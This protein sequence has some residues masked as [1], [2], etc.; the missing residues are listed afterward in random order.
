MKRFAIAVAI[1]VVL[2]GAA[3]I[4][5]LSD[6]NSA[7]ADVRDPSR[8]PGI[9]NQ[10]RT[11]MTDGTKG[12]SF[13]PASIPNSATD[14]RFF[15]RPHFLQGGA[16]LQIS[17]CLPD[18][19]IR[20]IAASPPTST[21]QPVQNVAIPGYLNFWVLDPRD[22]EPSGLPSDFKAYLID[23]KWPLSP[24]DVDDGYCYGIAISMQKHRI[25]YWAQN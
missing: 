12:L 16:I 24:T 5:F 14:I 1:V 17:Y 6:S 25:I 10:M 11:Q 3:A 8:Y 7:I 20:L 18:A 23:A 4:V 15:Y 21:T 22:P 19:A 2:L 13:F 9:L